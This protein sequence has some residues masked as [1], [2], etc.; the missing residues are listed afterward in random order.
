LAGRSPRNARLLRWLAF[1]LAFAVPVFLQAYTAWQD[2]F[3]TPSQLQANGIS[4]GLPFVA[5]GAMWSDATLLAGLMATIMVNYAHQWTVRQWATALALGSV[6]SAAMHWGL[7]VRG[8]LPE[9]HVHDGATTIAGW[10]HV[11]YMS[12]GLA[13]TML[14][15]VCTNLLN[16]AFVTFVSILLII[17]TI[18]G[19]HIPLRIWARIA[20]PS[21]Y[22][23][24]PIVDTP[25]FCTVLGTIILVCAGQAFALRSRERPDLSLNRHDARDP[26]GD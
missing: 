15:Y 5:H 16:A 9:A 24:Q 21:W 6:V 19:V 7:Y 4:K 11:P 17:H 14:F 13:V 22:A 2:G 25:A 23:G 20:T 3:L 8:P 10:M 1:Y 18:V 26:Y 12:F